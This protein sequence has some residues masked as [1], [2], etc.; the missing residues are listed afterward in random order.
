MTEDEETKLTAKLRK[1]EVQLKDAR[2]RA[3]QLDRLLSQKNQA[4]I[5][6]RQLVQ[7]AFEN[8]NES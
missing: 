3:N 5:E 4:L 2:L 6:I 8:I 1:L 7:Q